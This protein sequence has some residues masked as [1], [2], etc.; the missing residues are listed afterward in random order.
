MQHGNTF[1]RGILALAVVLALAG[2]KGGHEATPKTTGTVAPVAVSVA[3]V[4]AEEIQSGVTVPGTLRAARRAAISAKV[5]GQIVELTASLGTRVAAGE[6]LARV[7]VEEIGARLQQADTQLAQAERN[8]ARE[9]ALLEKKAA[10]AESVR[11]LEEAVR[12]ARAGRQ[13]AAT[14]SGYA[15][16]KAP[17]AGLV[18]RKFSEAGDLATPGQPLLQL[19]DEG[20]W[21][22]LA[23]VPE[24]LM[25]QINLGDKA[26]VQ[27][28]AVAQALEGVVAEIAPVVEPDSRTALVKFNL[29]ANAGLRSGQFARVQLGGPRRSAI[30]APL[31][32]LDREGQM[33]RVFVVENKQ[34]R[35]RI[36]RS[37]LQQDGRVEIL[38]GLA[39]G[40]TVVTDG[41]A[42]LRDGQTLEI[43]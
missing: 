38:A 13:E 7:S 2:C 19:E 40:D 31:T 6:Q 16:I 9:R 25:G 36:V 39:A 37:G 15:V 26:P 33:E 34:A 27:V 23:Q 35:M 20:H 30:L 22:V 29:P 3:Q 12:I 14:M 17:F 11:N 42:R 28:P 1:S 4:Q 41:A 24:S 32:A 8:L 5:S 43:R 21:Q 18:T 10:T